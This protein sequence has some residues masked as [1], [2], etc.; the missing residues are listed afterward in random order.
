MGRKERE[1]RVRARERAEEGERVEKRK[2]EGG[3]DLDICLRAREFPSYATE[4]P[5]LD[6]SPTTLAQR[7]RRQTGN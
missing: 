3:F 5:P 7:A 4:K 2:V 1:G 6:N